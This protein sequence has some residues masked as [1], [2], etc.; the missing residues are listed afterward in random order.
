MLLIKTKISQSK[1]AGVGLFADQFIPKG[2]PIWKFMPGFDL[3]VSKDQLQKLFFRRSRQ[4]L[5]YAYPN[6]IDGNS[7]DDHEGV[8]VVV[9]DIQQG[10]ELTENYK[11]FD[12]DFDYKMSIH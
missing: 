8:S 6:C 1:I 3:K 4:F 2:T 11:G 9:E 5:K 7:P 12:A 10:D